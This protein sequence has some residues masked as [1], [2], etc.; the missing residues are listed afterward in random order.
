MAGHVARMEGKGS[1]CK[2][3]FVGNAQGEIQ[4]GKIMRMWDDNIKN[5]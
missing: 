4:I 1:K 5:N 3:S 2:F